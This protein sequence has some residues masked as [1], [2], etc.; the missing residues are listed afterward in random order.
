[1]VRLSDGV[2]DG[3]FWKHDKSL[4]YTTRSAYKFIRD[5]QTAQVTADWKMIWHKCIPVK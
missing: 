4:T 5:K 2:T 1:G 3:W